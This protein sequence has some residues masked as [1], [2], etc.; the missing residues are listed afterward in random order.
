MPWPISIRFAT[1]DDAAGVAAV[2]APYCSTPISFELEPP[3]AVEISAR[4]A[5]V[6]EAYPWLVAEEDGA[7]VGYAYGS[8]HRERAAY[9]WS[10][11]VSV[12]VQQGRH[13]LGIGR[14]LYA[15]LFDLLRRQG[16]VNAYAGV[17]LPNPGSV[18]LHE[19]LGFEPVGVYRRV[20]Y[21]CGAW[22]DVAWYQLRLQEPTAPP[23]PPSAIAPSWTDSARTFRSS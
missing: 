21:K 7:I 1:P 9:R 14:R 18:G 2:Y 17:T 20:G 10:V 23:A 15:I 16:F 19:S 4:M 11:D 22:H 8:R 3:D 6:L 5:K 12:Y 13:R